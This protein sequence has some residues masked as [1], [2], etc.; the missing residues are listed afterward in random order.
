MVLAPLKVC[1]TEGRMSSDKAIIEEALNALDLSGTRGDEPPRY[2]QVIGTPAYQD[3]A[4]PMDDIQWTVYSESPTYIGTTPEPLQFNMMFH[5]RPSTSEAASPPLLVYPESSSLSSS[6]TNSAEASSSSPAKSTDCIGSAVDGRSPAI[7]SDDEDER[8]P[9]LGFSSDVSYDDSEENDYDSD[10]FIGPY[11]EHAPRNWRRH[12]TYVREVKEEEV[13]YHLKGEPA[14]EDDPRVQQGLDDLDAEIAQYLC[15]SC[16]F[17]HADADIH[18]H[19]ESPPL[20]VDRDA[21]IARRFLSDH[22]L[23]HGKPPSNEPVE[24]AAAE[25]STPKGRMEDVD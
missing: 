16:G 24:T 21:A 18:H 1:Q 12:V 8:V 15:A 7:P 25:S 6:Q 5:G 10:G 2:T 9:P 20:L 14:G 11:P 23:F 3:R 19:P 4:D 17:F 13:F 22:D